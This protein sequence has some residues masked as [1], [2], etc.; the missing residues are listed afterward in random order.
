[1][2][3]L[4]ELAELASISSSFVDKIGQTHF[5]TDKV[6]EF[7]LNAMGIKCGNE[8]EIEASIC[9]LKKERVIDHVMS[10]YDNEKVCF[11]LRGNGE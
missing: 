1:M 6:R 2:E 8:Q 4:R 7:F 11:S 9:E 5:T 10:F 3:K